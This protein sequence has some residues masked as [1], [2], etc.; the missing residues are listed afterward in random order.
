[1]C[2]NWL[3]GAVCKHRAELWVTIGY[4]ELCVERDDLWVT[5]GYMELCEDKMLNFVR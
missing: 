1:V 2:D 3:Y 4:M 5:V